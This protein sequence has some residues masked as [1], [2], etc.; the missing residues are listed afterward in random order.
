MTAEDSDESSVDF[1]TLLQKK[2]KINKLE[3]ISLPIKRRVQS[4]LK[5]L[6]VAQ[7]ETEAKFDA[8]VHLLK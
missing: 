2:R 7:I 1:N 8:E 6:I 3:N 4:A 5:K